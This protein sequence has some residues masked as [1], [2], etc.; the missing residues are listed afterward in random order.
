METFKI[1]V[2]L[3][4]FIVMNIN[5][6]TSIGIFDWMAHRKKIENLNIN[7][8]GYVSSPRLVTFRERMLQNRFKK[9][10]SRVEILK[11][12]QSFFSKTIPITTTEALVPDENDAVLGKTNNKAAASWV[13]SIYYGP[14]A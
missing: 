12:I 2:M 13:R 3:V 7:P 6:A 5:S 8:I 11:K 9:Y 10:E 4:I 14:S 1:V